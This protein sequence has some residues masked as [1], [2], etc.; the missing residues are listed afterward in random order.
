MVNATIERF[1]Y[2]ATLVA[3]TAHWMVLL[4]PQ[5]VTLGSLV[6]AAKGEATE[7]TRMVGALGTC[8]L[9]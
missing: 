9:E 3:E 7:I 8:G 6:I 5:A 1:G 4:R 2:P